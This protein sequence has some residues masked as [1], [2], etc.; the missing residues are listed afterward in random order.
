M[1]KANQKNVNIGTNGGN[2][3][4]AK[5]HGNRGKQLNKNYKPNNK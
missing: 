3:P 2:K 1:H 5:V 4:N